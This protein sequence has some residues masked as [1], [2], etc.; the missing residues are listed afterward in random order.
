MQGSIRNPKLM[1]LWIAVLIDILGFYIIIPFLPSFIEIYQTT[2]L[3]IGLLLAT[4]AIFTLF[5]AP[6]L[7]KLSDKYGR[8]PLL[9][10]SQ[11]GTM[12]AFLILAFSNSLWMLF[13]ARIVDGIFGGNFPIAKAIISDQTSPKDRGIQMTNFGVIHTIAGLVGPGLGG[14]LSIVKPLGD[15]YPVFAPGIGA[16]IMSFSTIVVTLFMLEESW[17]K[18]RRLHAKKVIKVKIQLRKNKDA[19]FLLTQFTI[20][21]IS[22]IMF[23]SSMGVYMRVVMGLDPF[24]IGM[25]MTISGISR[26]IV[27]FTVFKP[28]LRKLGEKKMTRLGLIILVISFFLIGF[29]REP[30]FLIILLIFIS[31]GVSCSRGLLISKTTQTVTPNHMGKINGY[32][33]TLDSIAQIVGPI[34]GTF[35]LTGFDPIFFGVVIGSVGLG[36]MLMDFNKIIPLMQRQK[37]DELKP[38]LFGGSES[39]QQ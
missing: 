11:A 39:Q 20:S 1:P 16:A 27:R 14:I 9:L 25:F 19:L 32:T 3:M 23:V 12:T 17:S 26:A 36:A 13:L 5:F 15:N 34:I 31:Y 35:I 7:G 6:I 38:E 18:E 37:F 30:I 29:A 10:I 8:K 28:T 24:A 22:F 4:N 21:S 33:T 2:P